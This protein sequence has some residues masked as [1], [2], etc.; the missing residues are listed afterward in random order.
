MF[1]LV[2]TRFLL[3]MN[4][5]LSKCFPFCLKQGRSQ[6]YLMISIFIS[7][8]DRVVEPLNS[9]LRPLYNR[10]MFGNYN[11]YVCS[12]PASAL[13]LII[14]CLSK[15]CSRQTTP[16]TSLRESLTV[17]RLILLQLKAS[18]CL[19]IISWNKTLSARPRPGGEIFYL[20]RQQK[21]F[22]DVLA[23]VLLFL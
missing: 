19:N 5:T 7:E 12:I 11:Q 17:E 23:T 16:N 13:T 22:M 4:P 10:N 15:V 18:H 3:N 14:C 6:G 9:V 8:L 20:N 21:E 1:P 2:N